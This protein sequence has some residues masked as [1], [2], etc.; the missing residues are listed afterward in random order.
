MTLGAPAGV[1]MFSVTCSFFPHFAPVYVL[2]I[3]WVAFLEER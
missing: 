3:A 1:G 2:K